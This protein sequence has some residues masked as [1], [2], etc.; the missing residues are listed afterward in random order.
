MHI[1]KN[2][3]KSVG[4]LTAAAMLLLCLAASILFGAVNYNWHTAW[5]AAFHY[6][7][8]VSEQVILR[9]TRMPRAFIAA[10]IGASL[11]IAGALMQTLTR[12]PLASPSVLGVNAGA[13]CLVVIA[14]VALS[15]SSMQALAWIAFIG[16]AVGAV[17]VY[18]L[19]SIGRDGLTPLKI[20]LAGSAMTALFASITQ[21]IL[22]LN[23]Q[24]LSSVLFWL[25]GTI[26]GRSPDM[27]MAVL[28]Y[29]VISWFAAWFISR[30]MNVLQMG[31]D[32]AKGLGQK[33]IAVKAL[34]GLIIVM[35]AGSAVSV[36]G[37]IAFIGIVIPHISR[38]FIGIDH[39]WVIPYCAVLGAI[40]LILADL[41]AR[42]MMIPEEMPVGVMTAVIGAPFFIYIARRGLVKS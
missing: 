18:A 24:G 33:T 28:P 10:A 35:L 8:N 25:T 34:A 6:D 17:T 20:V 29:M 38:F 14:A 39:R 16:A 5:Q 32:T 42:F 2:A 19:G 21:G 23:K 41:A 9:T 22:V 3:W 15:V 27:L 7:E 4:L 40:L 31:E 12:N 13:T 26:A 37:P 30:D 1:H 36:A 11:A